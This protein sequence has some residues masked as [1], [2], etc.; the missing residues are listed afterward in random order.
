MVWKQY[1][2]WEVNNRTAKISMNEY[3]CNVYIL[4]T[5]LFLYLM[6]II[7][8]CYG[9]SGNYILNSTYITAQNITCTTLYILI[10]TFERG[11]VIQENV[12]EV[13]IQFQCRVPLYITSH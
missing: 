10:S 1:Q 12:I 3:S 2:R 6:V 7:R 11:T 9:T 5:L 13:S 8:Y 4:M